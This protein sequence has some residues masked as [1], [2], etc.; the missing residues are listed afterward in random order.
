[1]IGWD[2]L[3]VPVRSRPA[4]LSRRVFLLDPAQGYYFS[5]VQPE[6]ARNKDDNDHNTDDVKNV[7]CTL[8]LRHARLCVKARSNEKK[9]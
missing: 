3:S 2:A 4:G 8:L 7:H 1:M 9:V 6:K 5:E